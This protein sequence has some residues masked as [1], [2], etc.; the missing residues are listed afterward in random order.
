MTSSPAG[1]QMTRKL[2]LPPAPARACLPRGA[3][4]GP[5]TLSP[6]QRP[7]RLR[8]RGR[9]RKER[10]QAVACNLLSRT[11]AASEDASARL[12]GPAGPGGGRAEPRPSKG[13]PNESQLLGGGRARRP[14]R[15]GRDRG[16]GQAGRSRRFLG[17]LGDTALCLGGKGA[18]PGSPARNRL[19]DAGPGP[20][21]LIMLGRP[22]LGLWGLLGGGSAALTGRGL[23]GGSAALAGSLPV[24]SSDPARGPNVRVQLR[25]S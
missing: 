7:L 17:R 9:A 21:P 2:P 6:S 15:P 24:S 3:A 16:R 14:S 13:T 8:G 12:V 20:G 22:S 1:T 4:P 25:V 5:G 23:G 10:L 18:G 19:L 11:E